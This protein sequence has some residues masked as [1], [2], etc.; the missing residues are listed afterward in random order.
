M[1]RERGN[2]WLWW[3]GSWGV[4]SGDWSKGVFINDCYSDVTVV[5]LMR[6]SA[7]GIVLVKVLGEECFGRV[8]GRWGVW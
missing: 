4:G 1:E 6:G 2:V 8:K 3:I 7:R 5:L